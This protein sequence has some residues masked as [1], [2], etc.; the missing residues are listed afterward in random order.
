MTDVAPVLVDI[1]SGVLGVSDEAGNIAV[2]DHE[3]ESQWRKKSSGK[4]LWHC[5]TDG[6]VHYAL[7]RFAAPGGDGIARAPRTPGRAV[8]YVA[9]ASGVQRPVQ[10][11][12][13]FAK[14]R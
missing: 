1:K 10:R 6:R 7:R 9:Q 8:R 14:M 12:R 2:F 11:S 4:Q 13:F 5:K 3:D